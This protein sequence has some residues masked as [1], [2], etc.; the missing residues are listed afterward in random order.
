ML[1]IRRCSC[2]SPQDQWMLGL[3]YIRNISPLLSLEDGTDCHP[4]YRSGR[5]VGNTSDARLT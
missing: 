2:E 5:G 4:L 3:I 1:A